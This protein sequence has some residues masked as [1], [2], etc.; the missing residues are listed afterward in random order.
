[1]ELQRLKIGNAVRAKV[2]VA[3]AGQTQRVRAASTTV[4][5]VAGA[6]SSFC[7]TDQ[8]QVIVG[9][10]QDAVGAQAALQR[11][12]A[13]AAHQGIGT[14]ATEDG[15][16]PVIQTVQREVASLYRDIDDRGRAGV[17]ITTQV[18]GIEVALLVGT[19]RDVVRQS[20]SAFVRR[21]QHFHTASPDKVTAA[22]NRQ[23]AANAQHIGSRCVVDQ[24][25]D[26]I[27][28]EQIC[29]RSVGVGVVTQAT[30]KG[31][32]ANGAEDEIITAIAIDIVRTR[33]ADQGVIALCALD[34]D[35]VER[36]ASEVDVTGSTCV[37]SR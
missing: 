11:V 26:L 8:Y 24:V 28:G 16:C 35:V 27:G 37:V 10:T 32:N 7:A 19:E 9:T 17:A 15:I 25:N 5:V 1:M 18:D 14:R 20:R 33:A 34:G 2:V 31:V 30:H 6:V 21:S 3:S 29:H 22:A 4:V 12:I 36:D 23:S 13:A